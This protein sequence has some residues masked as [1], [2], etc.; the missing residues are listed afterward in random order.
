MFSVGLAR[1]LMLGA[2]C[3]ILILVGLT[4]VACSPDGEIESRGEPPPAPSSEAT[5]GEWCVDDPEC[6]DYLDEVRARV[7][8]RWALTQDDTPGFVVVQMQVNQ[9][10]DLSALE[11]VESSDP[12]LEVSCL[13]AF[14]Q[15]AP[16]G[17]APAPIV[18]RTLHARFINGDREK[19]P[20][21]LLESLR[22]K[23]A[24]TSDP[25]RQEELD[26]SMGTVEKVIEFWDGHPDEPLPPDLRTPY[27]SILEEI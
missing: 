8:E 12:D 15:A 19:L 4:L 21:V 10:G 23:R 17:P 11:P 6:D 20:R 16:F 14:R 24:A 25:S 7:M 27:V 22:A 9:A 5:A 2:A 18:G 13:E 26:E 3:S 1:H